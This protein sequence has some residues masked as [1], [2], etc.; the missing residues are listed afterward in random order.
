MKK[1]ASIHTAA[2]ASG[3]ISPKKCDEPGAGP[4]CIARP[5][6]SGRIAEFL[7]AMLSIFYGG[8]N[9]IIAIESPGGDDDQQWLTFWVMFVTSMILEQNETSAS[10]IIFRW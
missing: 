2:L 3:L 4:F 1:T 10:F 7:G 9:S 5:S 8:Y 6:G